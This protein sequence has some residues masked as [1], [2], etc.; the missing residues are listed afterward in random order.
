[1]AHPEIVGSQN[2]RRKKVHSLRGSGRGGRGFK[3]PIGNSDRPPRHRSLNEG[4]SARRVLY[5]DPERLKVLDRVAVIV[6]DELA[7]VPL[8][9]NLNAIM[10]GVEKRRDQDVSIA[11]LNRFKSFAWPCDITRPHI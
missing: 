1:M 4:L 6:Q 2:G 7:V 3:S 8:D 11:P 10:K 9:I 5:F